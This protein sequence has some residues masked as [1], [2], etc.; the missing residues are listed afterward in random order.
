MREVD[1]GEH[2]E[3]LEALHVATFTAGEYS[4]DFEEGH[5]WIAYYDDE[6]VAFIGITQ[7]KLGPHVGYFLRVGV[8]PAH[9]GKGLQRR[10]M[11]V[12]EARAKKNGWMRIVSDTRN[13][14]YSANNIIA[15]G[16]RLFSPDDPW[17][18][19]DAL[20]WTKDLTNERQQSRGTPRRNPAGNRAYRRSRGHRPA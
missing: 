4:P 8:V 11:R 12:M 7:S 6:P 17:A 2:D 14:N 9:R 5:W 3:V 1:G 15:A 13:N 20:Y 18:H 16:Y 19:S 10:L